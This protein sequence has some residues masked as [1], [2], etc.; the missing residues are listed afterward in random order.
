MEGGLFLS[1]AFLGK[2]LH[3]PMLAIVEKGFLPTGGT[4]KDND[5]LEVCYDLKI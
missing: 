4:S 2:N 3:D 1:T 5:L